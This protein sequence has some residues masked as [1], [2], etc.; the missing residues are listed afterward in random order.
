[1]GCVAPLDWLK[2]GQFY[3]LIKFVFL[4]APHSA[5]YWPISATATTFSAIIDWKFLEKSQICFVFRSM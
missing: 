5:A 3:S 4:L 1:M 2:R